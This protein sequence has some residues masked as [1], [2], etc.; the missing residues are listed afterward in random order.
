MELKQSI[1]SLAV[2]CCKKKNSLQ[3]NE[4]FKYQEDLRAKNKCVKKKYEV[5]KR[6]YKGKRKGQLRDIFEVDGPTFNQLWQKM[7][8]YAAVSVT[9]S[10]LFT[11]REDLECMVS[12]IKTQTF[13]VLRFFGGTPYG[14]RFSDVY[15]TIVLNQLTTESRR[16]GR[17][18]KY[19]TGDSTRTLFS[20]QS[21]F[22]PLGNNEE[23]EVTLEGLLPNNH[24]VNTIDLHLDIPQNL[25]KPVELLLGGLS[26]A[27]VARRR[28]YRKPAGIQ[29]FR[30]ML[31][32]QLGPILL[33]QTNL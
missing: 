29:K 24:L 31:K 16:R 3:R 14:K 26:V 33:P 8:P 9:N 23:G 25:R 19:G 10:H 20:S 17:T 27:E 1:D 18:S 15:R 7:Y 22:A 28:G 30:S 11:D 32:E 12:D 6:Y 4:F 21:L 13:Y 2:L 5:G